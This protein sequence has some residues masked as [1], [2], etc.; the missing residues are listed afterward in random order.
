MVSC[1][2]GAIFENISRIEI[3]YACFDR[4]VHLLRRFR[5]PI[6]SPYTPKRDMA[7]EGRMA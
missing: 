1:E 3:K 6:A 4:Q 5:P 7:G 2:T